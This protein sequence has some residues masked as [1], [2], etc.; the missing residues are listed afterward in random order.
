MCINSQGDGASLRNLGLWGERVQQDVR[1]Q[2]QEPAPPCPLPPE[3]SNILDPGWP[4]PDTAFT[5]DWRFFI[6]QRSYNP[7]FVSLYFPHALYLIS[8]PSLSGTYSLGAYLHVYNSCL[9]F[10]EPYLRVNHGPSQQR[11]ISNRTQK[12]KTAG[13]LAPAY[14]SHETRAGPFSQRHGFFH[15]K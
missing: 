8:A 12:Q 15:F 5:H 14:R 3:H 7:R 4:L 9:P 2:A 10:P 13:I 1:D 11:K 6:T